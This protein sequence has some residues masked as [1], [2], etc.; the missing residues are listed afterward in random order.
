MRARDN[1]KSGNTKHR[2]P[3]FGSVWLALFML[4]R[5]GL[6]APGESTEFSDG[7]TS[8]PRP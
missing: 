3:L 6:T 7:C 5:E 4:L 1:R 2:P 8:S